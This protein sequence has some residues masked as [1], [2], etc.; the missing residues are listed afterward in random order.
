MPGWHM[1]TLPTA[2]PRLPPWV[3]QGHSGTPYDMPPPRKS[4]TGLATGLSAGGLALLLL[5]VLGSIGLSTHH[6]RV[7]DV[8]YQ[9]PVPTETAATSPTPTEQTTTLTAPTTTQDPTTDAATTTV[10]YPSGSTGSEPPNQETSSGPRPVV[11]LGGNPLFAGG[12]GL[13]TLN[14]R[15]PRFTTSVAGQDRFNRAAID[16]L[17]AAWTPLM[18][19]A[20][21]PMDTP[22]LVEVP[23]GTE[24]NP[25]GARAWKQTAWYCDADET[26]Y[27]TPNHYAKVEKIGAYP[28]VYLGQLAHEFGHHVQAMSGVSRA[29]VGRR[30]AAGQD[31]DAGLQLSRRLELQAQCFSGM[32]LAAT[33][34]YGSVTTGMAQEALRDNRKRGDFANTGRPPDHGLP[35][36]SGAWWKQGYDRNLTSQCNT[37][38]VPS[39]AVA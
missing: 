30:T 21:L 12:L 16:C 25:C 29:Y 2:G 20:G 39:N 19:Q 8:G 11:A 18:R 17:V 10:D 7:A 32:F 26:I 35:K 38:K 34:G 28:G 13:R 4:R 14:C 31:S 22:R 3:T 15:L 27:W 33:A 36:W 1:A 37:W 24:G 5:I 23:S 6:H 9:A